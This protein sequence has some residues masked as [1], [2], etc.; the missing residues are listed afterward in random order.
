[1]KKRK[2]QLKPSQIIPL[3]FLGLILAG[4][5]LLMLPISTASGEIPEFSTALFTSTSSVCVT[6]NVVVDTFSYWSTFGHIVILFL[7]QMGGLGIVAVVSLVIVTAKRRKS[8]VN[9]MLLRDSFNLD[10]MRGVAPFISRVFK[11]TIVVEALGAFGYFFAFIPQFGVVRG[12][13]ISFFT[14]VSAFCNAGMDIIGPN[15]LAPYYNRPLVLI[16]TMFL[17]IAGGIG[18]VIWF[19]IWSTH[20]NYFV[21]KRKR[22]LGMNEHTKLVLSM[23]AI[24]IVGGAVLIFF[25]EK[26]NPAT[27][28]KMTLWEK[29]LNSTFQ[30]VTYRT[31]G[32]VTVPQEA[33]LEPTTVI[34]DILM[35]IGGSPVGTAGGVKTV[36]IYVL[37]V[38]V[39]SCM[40]G[41]YEPMAFKRR[42]TD[43]MI[44]KAT[45]IV[46]FHFLL[47]ILFTFTLMIYEGIPFIDSVYEVMSGLNT[48]G[49]SR[50]ITADL[51]IEG[52]IIMIAAMYLGR[53]GPVSIA[54]FFPGGPD[55]RVRSSKGKF[56][57]G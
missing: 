9:M 5:V 7:I 13:W 51:N 57:I 29:M 31:A 35:F 25:L 54:L 6:G 33:L 1:M 39:D 8:L 19:D 41:N 20:R 24:L 34:G 40:R 42:I 45:A 26:N 27:I 3:G 4:T 21:K 48:V 10:S 23:T 53:I 50:G 37:F 30:S 14:S 43:D 56:I 47:A 44:R 18:Y 2:F 15:S 52:R 46:V 22:G 38:N 11:G 36:T 49:V 28:G 17:I 55:G 32:F 16:V 12:V